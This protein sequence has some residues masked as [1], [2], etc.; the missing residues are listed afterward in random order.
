MTPPKKSSTVAKSDA[1][2]L[3]RQYL[4]WK[5]KYPDAILMFRVGDFYEMFYE[6][7]VVASEVLG[8]ALTTRDRNKDNPVPLSGIPYHALKTYLTRLL[9][10]GHKVA[11]CEQT[12][13]PSQAKGLVRREVTEVITPGLIIDED[14][15]QAKLANYIAA[16]YGTEEEGY[17]LAAADISTGEFKVAFVRDMDSVKAEVARISPREI[18]LDDTVRAQMESMLQGVLIEPV[19]EVSEPSRLLEDAFG[20]LT[21]PMPEPV[22]MAAAVLLDTLR[23]ARPLE[24]LARLRLIP[25]QPGRFMALDQTTISNL[26]L[27]ETIR[28]RSRRG[29]L[30]SVL[31]ETVTAMGGRLLRQWIVYPLVTIEEINARQ[32]AIQ[33][34]VSGPEV[35]DRLRGLLKGMPD[36]ERLTSKVAH[37]RA[38]PRD[39]SSIRRALERIPELRAILSSLDRVPDILQPP[40]DGLRPLYELLDRAISDEPPARASD[41]GV[42]RPGFNQELDELVAL[43]SG[44]RDA[45]VTME[46]RERERTGIANLKIGYNRVFGYY[47]EVPRSRLDRVPE[48]YIRKQTLRNSERFITQELTDY[49]ARILSAEEKRLALEERLFAELVDTVLEYQQLLWQ[50]AHSVAVLDVVASLAHVAHMRDYVRPKVDM[51]D[52]LDLSDVRHPVIEALLP[53]GQFVP[54]DLKLSASDRQIL[55]ITGPNMAGKSTVIREVALAVLMAQMGSFVPA[56][57]ARIG[58]VD[59]IFTRVGASDNIS[60]GQSTFMVEMQETSH[61]LRHATH[62]SLVI[63]DE[64]GRGTSTYDGVSIAWSVVEYLHDRI[65]ARTLFA[66]HYH[67]LTSITDVKPRVR[68]A[69]MAVRELRGEIVLVHRL[70]PGTAGR[71]YGIQVA[72][73]AGLPQEVIDRAKTVLRALEKGESLVVPGSRLKTEEQQLTL[74]EPPEKEDPVIRRLREIDPDSLSPRQALEIL[75]DLCTIVSEDEENL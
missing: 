39:L 16:V 38:T 23:E 9:D 56:S 74:F 72:R 14:Q 67:E 37:R 8:I 26:E 20:R 48:Y 57:K 12:E 4:E 64:I 62:R 15:L 51:S 40:D 29:T 34:L 55:L 52:K 35:R 6:D 3:M 54:H 49:E 73:L 22:V 75:Y 69:A 24:P 63:L 28:D 7:A 46:Q 5:E 19:T 65:G 60:Q 42:F 18:L 10:A 47:I 32:D 30:V 17:G 27:L 68:N 45:L 58:L 2:P 71:S 25:Y 13:D 11:I 59:R 31:D 50:A 70:V 41:G 44:G 61:I 66:T 21:E 33:A 1:T 36:L 53:P 43:S